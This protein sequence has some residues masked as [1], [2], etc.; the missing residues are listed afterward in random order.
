MKLVEY[1][2]VLVSVDARLPNPLVAEAV[3][4]GRLEPFEGCQ[5]FEREVG[6]GESRIDFRLHMPERVVW[7]EAKSVTLVED[8]V[9][10]FPDAP[11]IRGSRHVRA[12]TDIVSEEREAAIVFVVQRQ[13]ARIFSPHSEADPVFAEGLRA[14]ADAGVDLQAWTCRV[15]KQAIAIAERIPVDLA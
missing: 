2:G 8:G 13:D 6:L 15:S 10:L 4:G 3:E 12:L 11:T 5:S 9:A 14:A 7:V 1:A